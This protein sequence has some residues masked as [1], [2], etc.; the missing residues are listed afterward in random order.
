MK[1]VITSSCGEKDVRNISQFYTW[2][3]S[4]NKNY[5]NTKL[6]KRLKRLG[7]YQMLFE[8]MNVDQA[9]NWSREKTVERNLERM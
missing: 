9:A 7:I 2:Q 1:L 3:I 4:R 6:G 8:G 5:P